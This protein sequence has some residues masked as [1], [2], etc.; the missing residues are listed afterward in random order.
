M[1]DID[2]AA[3]PITNNKKNYLGAFGEG[4]KLIILTQKSMS[5]ETERPTHHSQLWHG[6][7]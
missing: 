6:E 2:A 3:H 5:R 4:K 1:L 7:K